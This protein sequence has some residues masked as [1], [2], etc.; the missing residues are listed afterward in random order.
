M[1]DEQAIAALNALDGADEERDHVNADAILMTVLRE[2][3]R[4]EVV[5]AWAEARRRVGFWYA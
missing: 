3:G 4:G 1:T 2:V 5:D